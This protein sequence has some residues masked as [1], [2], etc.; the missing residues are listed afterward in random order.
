[1][2]TS[3]REIMAA[4]EK[5]VELP[6][7]GYTVK[8]RKIGNLDL[9]FHGAKGFITLDGRKPL[10][11]EERKA[12]PEE[13]QMK[14]G[15][16]EYEG[17]KK[18]VMAGLVSPRAVDR[19][20]DEIDKDEE[21]AVSLLD[22]DIFWLAMAILEHSGLV[23]NGSSEKM[24]EFFRNRRGTSPARDG[25]DLRGPTDGNPLAAVPG[26]HAEPADLSEGNGSREAGIR[27]S[28][29]GHTAGT[30]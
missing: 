26:I 8:I 3:A 23:A 14:L 16:E 28:D 24:A 4:A 9:V 19:Q 25:E 21:I 20:W 18:I 1:M 15:L 5:D 11:A 13:E 6:T 10:S 2:V 22:P 17:S 29:E 30:A 27:T 7:L 12:L